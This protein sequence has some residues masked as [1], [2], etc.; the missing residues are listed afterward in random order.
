LYKHKAPEELTRPVLEQLLSLG[1][2]ATVEKL[3]L[4]NLA[5]IEALLAVSTNNLK[6]LASRLSSED[7]KTVASYLPQFSPE[8]KN[9]FVSR[10]VSDPTIMAQLHGDGVR[11]HLIASNDLDATLAFLAAP[12]DLT[13]LY[14]DVQTVLTGRVGMGLFLYK[15]GTGQSTLIGLGLALL[16]LVMVRLLYGLVM[17]LVSPVT[18]LFRRSG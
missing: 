18:G 9:A 13:S 5:E 12:K 11:Q 6:A 3:A 7:L 16:L 10:V 1:D 2:R 4:L 17:W 8:Q 15:Y 14:G